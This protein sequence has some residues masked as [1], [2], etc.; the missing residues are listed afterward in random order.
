MVEPKRRILDVGLGKGPAANPVLERELAKR[1]YVYET[2]GLGTEKAPVILARALRLRNKLSNY[3]FIMTS[4]Y[5]ASFGVNLRLLLTFS[6]TKHVTIGLNQSRRLLRTGFRPVDKLIELV[7]Q[8]TDL[9][10][11][12]SRR[13]AELFNRIHGIPPNRFYFS[14]WGYDL[15]TTAATRFSAWPKRYVCLV[16]RNNRDID[17]FIG[18][19]AGTDIDGV[20]ITSAFQNAPAGPLPPNIHLFRDLPLDE[21]LDCIKNAA[22][23]VVLLKDNERGAGHITIV[24][25]M[26][27]GTPQI[28]SD[29]DVIKDYVVDGVSAIVVPLRDAQAVRRAIERLLNDRSCAERLS[30]NGRQYAQ[31]WLTNERVMERTV[32]ALDRLMRGEKIDTVDPEWLHAYKLFAE[33]SLARVPPV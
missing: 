14:L 10:V 27:S 28:V 24:A 7:F 25:A 11:V 19:V 26:F 31:R 22:A 30:A 3:D 9:I 5:F 29:V 15:P 23:N 33:N 18:A 8:R 4:E 2:C 12:H 32:L 6:K 1:G 21:T 17:T 16:G 20:V 13:E